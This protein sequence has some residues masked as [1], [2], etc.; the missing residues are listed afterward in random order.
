MHTME[1]NLE[2]STW[3]HF[4]PQIVIKL[5]SEECNF[6]KVQ[7]FVFLQRVQSSIEQIL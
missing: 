2:P 5:L 1:H 4:H 3:G 7:I 6:E